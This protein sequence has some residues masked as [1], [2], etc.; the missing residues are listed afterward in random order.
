MA[1]G[2][3]DIVIKIV[4]ELEPKI[5]EKEIKQLANN[6]KSAMER[7]FWD[8]DKVVTT[9]L[10]RAVNDANSKVEFGG[11]WKQ[12]VEN[13]V[14][15]FGKL[16]EYMR[17]TGSLPDKMSSGLYQAYSNVKKIYDA[18][19]AANKEAANV[20]EETKKVT[21]EYD[22]WKNK[23]D[24]VNGQYTDTLVKI[25]K[26]EDAL[27]DAFEV[28]GFKEQLGPNADILI[29]NFTTLKDNIVKA[30]EEYDKL[31]V[32]VEQDKD[33]WSRPGRKDYYNLSDDEKKKLTAEEQEILAGIVKLQEELNAAESNLTNKERALQFYN[34]QRD[35]LEQIYELNKRNA[36]NDGNVRS[37]EQITKELRTAKE[38]AD[39]LEAELD[40]VKTAEPEK[41]F[42]ASEQYKRA[43]EYVKELEAELV[44]AAAKANEL[45]EKGDKAK[46]SFNDLRVAGFSL[47]RVLGSISAVGSDIARGARR[48]YS[49]YM[50]IW[51][52]VKKVAGAFKNLGKAIRGTADEHSQSLKKMIKDIFRYSFGIR[53]LF[54]LFRRLRKYIKEAFTAMAEQ[55]P[56]VNA[57][58]ASLKSSLYALK[59]SLAT[60]FEPILS[61]IAPALIR[62]IDLLAK[63]I[64][65]IGMFWAAL[66]GRGY[67]YQAKKVAQTI[68]ETAGAAK[69]LNKQLQGFDELNNLTTNNG[70][71]GGGDN[72]LAE[73]EKVDV[74]EWIKNLADTLKDAWN[75]FL[76]P[77]KD[78]WA[79]VGDEVVKA[80]TTAFGKVKNLLKDIARDFLDVWNSGLG[81]SISTNIL[82]I[83][84][85]IGNAIGNLAGKINEAWNAVEEG[86]SKSNGIRFWEAI[87][88][89]VDKVTA[90]IQRITED[91]A[92]WINTL[93]LTPAFT[94][95]VHFLESLVPVAQMV[96]DI[97]FNLWDLAFKPIL[98]WAFDGENSGIARFFQLLADFNNKLDKDKIVNDLNK[99]W[100]ALGRFGINIGEG[101][102]K[103]MEKML[104]YLADWLNS[105]DFTQWCQDVADFLDGLDPSD[106]ADDLEQVVRIVKNI[107][108]WVWKA[109]KYVI[110]HKDMILDVL[111]WAS[112]H[113]DTIAGIIVGGKLFIDLG[114]LLINLGVFFGAVSKLGPLFQPLVTIFQWLIFNGLPALGT[115]F[116]NLGGLIVSGVETGVSGLMSLLGTTIPAVGASIG[117]TLASGL[118]AAFV[119]AQ[120]G[121][122]LVGPWLHPEDKELYENFRWFEGEDSFF[123]TIFNE[124]PDILKSAWKEMW[125][126]MG[127]NVKE[128]CKTMAEEMS[129][130]G[131]K[132]S[133]TKDAI[134][135][136][137]ESLKSSGKTFAENS[138]EHWGSTKQAVAEFAKDAGEKIASSKSHFEDLR[139]KVKDKMSDMK[140]SISDRSKDIKSS[141]E[142][143][144]KA[145]SNKKE[146]IVKFTGDLQNKIKSNFDGI[147]SKLSDFKSNWNTQFDNLK[148]KIDTFKTNVGTTLNNIKDSFIKCFE[149]I[150][151]GIRTP[152]NAILGFVEKLVNGL[153][154]GVNKMT[155]ALGSLDIDVP[156]WVPE[157]GGKKFELS[158][159]K[160]NHISLPRLAQGAV[161]PP[162]NEFLAVLGDQKRGTNIETPLDTM[163][164]AF[165][166]A[167]KGGNEQEIALLQEQNQ[168]LRQLLQKEFGISQNDIFKSVINQNRIYKNST[169][170][171]A[172][173]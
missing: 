101:L 63:V 120:I 34:K 173:A 54:M 56:E 115:L 135:A 158:I 33:F 37:V 82:L 66:T 89:I 137:L 46:V 41:Q 69:E 27:T 159:P 129:D 75:K 50:K 67:V 83:I 172:L 139:A 55:I 124:D 44:N 60:A 77:I 12:D 92:E 26:L 109:I 112:E 169:G 148:S 31:L 147:K 81:E 5:L 144:A 7:A 57:M 18:Y 111:E 106:L 152:I 30:K 119:G 93:N 146:D 155:S 14:S 85:D 98:T 65:Y 160:I 36:D 38:E 52:I 70:G 164:Q 10:S 143:M 3:K 88:G 128:A 114:R 161:I 153:I 62:L 95:F 1:D 138:K 99:I 22:A 102:L 29:R 40:K 156:D 11:K 149:G 39:K 79:K 123:S 72:P 125:G 130:S 61:A 24:A 51:S 4:P 117:T 76:Q 171:S 8:L 141:F 23:L 28:Q 170:V 58:L 150:K 168:L 105:D 157:I 25:G 136:S 71:G 45:A 100:E 118:I 16:Q 96:M 9:S 13:V 108:E 162:N 134:S 17:E 121:Q 19:I 145:I 131:N 80:W 84:R 86:A 74:P 167:N 97:L 151:N 53:S 90:G 110:D 87:L 94:A 32:A 107:A 127:A 68:G 122:H 163:V 126:D 15:E 2:L 73:F 21:P 116:S 166:M 132:V 140:T 43:V 47:F 154:D 78:A 42:E 165:N 91:I 49:F 59:G 64:T 142:D 133:S 20:Y 104:D 6:S 48:I 35:I 113:L 103:F